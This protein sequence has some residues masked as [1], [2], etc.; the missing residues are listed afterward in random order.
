MGYIRK[1]LAIIGY[2]KEIKYTQKINSVEILILYQLFSFLG[3]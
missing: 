2:G 1:I 3:Y